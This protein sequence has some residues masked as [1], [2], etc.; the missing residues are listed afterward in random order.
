[1]VAPRFLLN[2]AHDICP[3]YI[4]NTYEQATQ[5]RARRQMRAHVHKHKSALSHVLP[6]F[7]D[8]QNTFCFEIQTQ[9]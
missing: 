2:F 9:R 7:A 5:A 4:D 1:M 3:S 6:N 8:A